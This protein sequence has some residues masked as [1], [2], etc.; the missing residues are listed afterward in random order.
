MLQAADRREVSLL[1]MLHLSAALD[2]V[3]HDLLAVSL[4]HMRP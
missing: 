4:E 2:T 1:C 3:D